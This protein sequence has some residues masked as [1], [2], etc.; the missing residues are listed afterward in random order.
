MAHPRRELDLLSRGIS[1]SSGS[2]NHRSP[3]EG[4]EPDAELLAKARSGD[5]TAFRELVDRY[6]S[7][8]AAT[9]IGM[10][11]SGPDAEEV[12]QETFIRFYRSLGRFRGDAKITTYLTRIAINLSL[13]TLRRRKRDESRFL[14]WNEKD[15]LP[16]ELVVQGDQELDA[17]ERK[18]HVRRA[19]QSLDPKHR[20]VV[21]MRMINGYSTKETAAL[22]KIPIGTVLS[23]LAR[24]Q[25]KLKRVLAPYVEE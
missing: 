1:H 10:L 3:E 6:E 11:G 5:Q 13:D 14:S 9:V 7:I 23:R 24:A 18:E 22:L 19:V 12:G 8:V 15:T 20:A 25:D 17:R 21:V 16:D 2:S 4:H